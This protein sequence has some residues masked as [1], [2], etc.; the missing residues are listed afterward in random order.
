M[1]ITN[2]VS[3]DLLSD[4]D[5]YKASKELMLNANNQNTLVDEL[6][7]KFHGEYFHRQVF[8]MH[9]DKWGV[10]IQHAFTRRTGQLAYSVQISFPSNKGDSEKL[11]LPKLLTE[12]DQNIRIGNE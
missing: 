7:V 8:V 10:L 1:K 5:Y 12:L 3:K 4:A 9:T 11:D 6:D 2:D